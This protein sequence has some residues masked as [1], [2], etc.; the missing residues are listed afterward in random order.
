MVIARSSQD[1]DH[2]SANQCEPKTAANPV[3]P[4]ASEYN[5]R[6]SES[7]IFGSRKMDTPLKEV[8][9]ISHARISA[10]A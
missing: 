5:F 6:C 8:R 2:F 1:E 3:L 10:F 7:Y 4:D 9:K